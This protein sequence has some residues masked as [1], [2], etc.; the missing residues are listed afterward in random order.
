MP[1]RIETHR[2][3][4]KAIRTI[5]THLNENWLV[6][7][8]EERDYGIDLQLE[9]FDLDD[10]TGDFIFV[11]VKGTNE[12][13]KEKVQLSGFPVDTIKYAL[14][15][16]VP[17]FIFHTS[18]TSKQTK[19]VWLQN[20]VETHLEKYTPHWKDQKSVTI[21]FPKENDLELNDSKIA[22]IINKDKLRKVGVKFLA[23]Y[24][25]LKLHSESVLNAGQTDV[26]KGCAIE[27]RK[28]QKLSLFINEYKELVF[29]G[30]YT[31]FNTFQAAYDNIANTSKI[32]SADR[33]T[34]NS[35][36][37]FLEEIKSVF[38]NQDL[39]EELAMEN[40]K[41]YHPY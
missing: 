28:L 2:I 41:D 24:E 19:Y 37:C 31:D 5:F 29:K 9:R 18:N 8:L 40:T 6:R 22:E 4:T 23:S 36:M 33:G 16:D 14:M 20:Y 10:A 21:Y 32:D 11:Q 30:N 12:E 15:F 3:D 13:F 25:S 17:F 1:T 27:A 7:N 35:A 34:I 38:L 26:A 39:F